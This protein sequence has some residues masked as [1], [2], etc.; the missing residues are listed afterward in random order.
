[1][2]GRP[3]SMTTDFGSHSGDERASKDAGDGFDVYLSE[4][5]GLGLYGYCAPD[6]KRIYRNYR[7]NDLAGY[8]VLDDDYAGFPGG[9]LPNLQVTAAHE[10]FHAIQFAY[11]SLEDGWFMEGTAA[12]IEDEVY[13]G[14]DDNLQY[15]SKSQLTRPDKPLDTSNGIAVY[16]SWGFFRYLSEK[17]GLNVVRKAWQR[18]DSIKDAPDDYSLKGV[19]KAIE[20]NGDTLGTIFGDYARANLAPAEYY[21]EGATYPSPSVG[22]KKLG[23]SNK[24][25]GWLNSRIDHMAIAY[26]AAKPTNRA[27]L[28]AKLPG[29]G[30]CTGTVNRVTSP[31]SRQV[32][33]W[34]LRHQASLTRR[35]RS[36]VGQ[37]RLRSQRGTACLCHAGQRRRHFQQVLPFQHSSTRAVVGYRTRTTAVTRSRCRSPDRTWA[38]AGVGTPLLLAHG[39]HVRPHGVSQRI[40]RSSQPDDIARCSPVRPSM[41]TPCVQPPGA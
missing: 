24:S 20:S 34:L 18:A 22:A 28:N 31:R 10:F 29:K 5:G 12:W 19:R 15:L 33:Q 35:Q 8:C 1:M 6:D 38:A 3:K 13:D 36:W 9:S 41:L 2:F 25:T 16:G 30:G 37:G 39:V 14:V 21:D 40:P 32:R 4:I 23:G 17:Y 26:R 7:Y 27:G 11:D